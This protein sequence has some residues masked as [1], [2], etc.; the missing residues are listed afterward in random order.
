MLAFAMLSTLVRRYQHEGIHLL[1]GTPEA[2]HAPRRSVCGGSVQ[3]QGRCGQ[4]VVVQPAPPTGSPLDVPGID[5]DLS[6]D[7]IV[8]FIREGRRG[9]DDD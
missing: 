6:A 8:A 7:G 2:R 9:G 3:I 5:L 4:P 1:G